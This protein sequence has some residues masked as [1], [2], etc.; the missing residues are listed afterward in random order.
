M[1]KPVPNTDTLSTD[2]AALIARRAAQRWAFT[3]TATPDDTPPG[4]TYYGTNEAAVRAAAK[5]H[6]ARGFS[7][8]VHRPS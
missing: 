6:E 7:V 5:R 4:F 2:I 1:A 3:L 8:E